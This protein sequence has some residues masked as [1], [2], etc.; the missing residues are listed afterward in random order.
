MKQLILDIAEFLHFRQ[1][2][3]KYKIQFTYGL[4]NGI[5]TVKANEKD[6]EIIGY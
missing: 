6:L 3:E 2:A 1:V 5:A 4:K